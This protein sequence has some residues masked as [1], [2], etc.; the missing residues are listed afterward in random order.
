M[1]RDAVIVKMTRE[2]RA[3]RAPAL[4]K[5]RM[6]KAGKAEK[7]PRAKGLFGEKLL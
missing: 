2:L 7:K 5:S 4:E 1:L 3:I 6:H